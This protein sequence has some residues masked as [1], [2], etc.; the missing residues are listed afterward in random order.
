MIMHYINKNTFAAASESEVWNPQAQDL[1]LAS[2]LVERVCRFMERYPL[3]LA[4]GEQG[5]TASAETA[6][7]LDPRTTAPSYASKALGAFS[8]LPY[9]ESR[10]RAA[11]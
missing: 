9:Q 11:G 6:V 1:P 5:A 7:C 2:S 3:P 8:D 4:G 10:K